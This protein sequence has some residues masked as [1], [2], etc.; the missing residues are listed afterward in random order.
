MQNNSSNTIQAFWVAMGS[1]S[2]FAL[3]I[4]SAAILSRYFD[5]AEYGTYRQILYVYNTLLVIF[6]AGLPRV[7]AYFLPRYSL[8]QG[9]YIVWKVSRLL[10]FFGII[11]SI[12]LF[13]FSDLIA[14]IL[15][16]PELGTGLKYFS[17]IPMLLLPTL[18]IEGIFSTY[19]KTIY[20]A[21]YNTLTRILMLLFIVMPVIILNGSYL[22]AIYGWLAVS[23][24]SFG[25]AWYFKGIPFRNVSL[26][27]AN[28]RFKEI[29]DYSIPL[30]TASLAGIA[31]KSADQFFI[32]RYFGKEVFAEYANGFIQLPFVGMITS[33][34]SVV[35]MPMFSKMIH[36]KADIK[37]ITEL[38]Q[39][40]LEKSA[41]LIFPLI[42][43]FIFHAK[44]IV[45]MLY[46]DL[47]INSTIYFQIA[48]FTNFFNII[49][50]APLLFS[51]GETKFYFWLHFVFAILIWAG[52]YLIVIIINNPIAIAAFSVFLSISMT[53]VAIKKV[54]NL[55]KVSFTELFPLKQFSII[56]LHSLIVIVL[57][58]I[59]NTLFLSTLTKPTL[60]LFNGFAFLL[61]ILATAELFKIDYLK[62]I[63]PLFNKMKKYAE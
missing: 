18:G 41:I 59:F 23:F 8:E 31:I 26:K 34:T 61:I 38:W 36:E 22:Y 10:L 50:F 55:F 45:L 28:L 56:I 30:L 5:K 62:S 17:P 40:A 14:Q 60:M 54:T 7:F 48:M 21:I 39:S 29:F 32:S 4:I 51:L 6:S 19:K 16:N 35:L 20:I 49:I 53:I 24:L 58:M 11:F 44:T 37:N 12:I 3:G 27:K 33:A 43:F 57:I 52:E 15:K 25:I 1:L 2:S 42:V 47:Y 13:F 63:R 9:K 46:S